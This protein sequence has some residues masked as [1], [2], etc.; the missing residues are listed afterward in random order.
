MTDRLT[1]L[2]SAEADRLD[3]PSPPA[4]DV[5]TRGRSLRR[6]HRAGQAVAGLAVLAVIGSGVVY[7][8]DPGE[9]QGAAIDPAA[10]GEASSDRGVGAAFAI[11]TTVYL[12]EGETS[13]AIDD[14]AVKS[15]YYTSAG[16][17]V[18]HGNNSYSD[19]GGPQRFSLIT[20][21]GTVKPLDLV[22]EETVHAT[23][24]TQPYVVYVQRVDK[25]AT[26][27]VRDVT[28][29]REVASVDLPDATDPY[30]SPALDGDTV[31]VRNGDSVFV[32]D[33][34]SGEVAT[35]DSLTSEIVAGGHA[36]AGYGESPTIIE[37]STGE[38]VLAADLAPDSYGYF[39]LS[40]DG[41]SALLAAEDMNYVE[42]E[43][44][45]M[46]SVYDVTSGEA[47]TV[48]GAS[49]DFGWTAGGDLFKVSDD[50]VLTTCAVATGDCSEAQLDL[51][52]M[53]DSNYLTKSVEDDLILGGMTRES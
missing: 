29:D 40:P 37:V 13:A 31:Y 47:A 32:V 20:P 53:P 3:V 5:L 19:G 17:L 44:V 27:H 41:S 48:P 18:R 21:E 2:M 38:V 12:D 14:K 7:L 33:W 11:G 6:R 16:V 46:S 26:L 10:A 43:T 25:V 4:A 49:Y 22:T 39:R 15:L 45:F 50:G 1:A 42:G 28:T 23:D 34:R 9:E 8:Q 36:V 24:P 52:L 30:S 35:S 51:E